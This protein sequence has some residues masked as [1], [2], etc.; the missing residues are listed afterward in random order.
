[1]PLVIVLGDPPADL[2]RTNVAVDSFNLAGAMWGRSGI[3]FVARLCR[4]LDIPVVVL[5]DE[6]HYPE[7]DDDRLE[8]GI[9]RGATDKPRRIA[10]GVSKRG[11]SELAIELK[12]AVEGL[13]ELHD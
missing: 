1:M 9:G 5:H 2:R 6:D 11:V 7:P 10:D 12:R 4:A 13:L 3:P 8:L